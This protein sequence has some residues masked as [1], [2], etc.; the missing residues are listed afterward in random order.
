MY[1]ATLETIAAIYIEPYEDTRDTTSAMTNLSSYYLSDGFNQKKMA[2]SETVFKT[3]RYT[4]ERNDKF[5][6]NYS[7]IFKAYN[8][9]F[10]QKQTYKD[11]VKVKHLYDSIQ[12]P[13]NNKIQVTKALIL[14]TYRN[15]FKVAMAYFPLRSIK[16][17]HQKVQSVE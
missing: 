17:S 9:L 12:V 4:D 8:A 16:F 13:N 1:Q 3:A 11:H 7:A 10:N 15:D 6:H 14:T 5:E 2:M